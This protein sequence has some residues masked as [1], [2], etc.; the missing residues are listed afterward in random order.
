M[1]YPQKPKSFQDI[2]NRRRQSVFVG[3]EEQIDIFRHNINL[4]M[5]YPKRRYAQ[6]RVS[7]TSSGLLF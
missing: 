3:R 1:N 7:D 6:H 2:L 4:P 5:N